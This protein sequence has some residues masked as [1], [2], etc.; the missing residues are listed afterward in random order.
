MKL[1]QPVNKKD[2]N[3]QMWFFLSSNRFT[4]NSPLCV[5]LRGWA[6]LS[7]SGSFPSP[8]Y[9]V[10]SFSL[11]I[12]TTIHQEARLMSRRACLTHKHATY[13]NYYFTRK[14]PGG[15]RE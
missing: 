2:K 7:L 15:R 8:F 14:E 4:G 6:V 9:K 5:Y 1:L 10:A 12:P 11:A 3:F 13:L